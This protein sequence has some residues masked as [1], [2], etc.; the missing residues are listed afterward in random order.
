MA[1][2]GTQYYLSPNLPISNLSIFG[3]GDTLRSFAGMLSPMAKAP[4]EIA[5]DKQFFTRQPI[6]EYEG[7]TANYAGFELPAK[8][9][10]F[11][12]QLGSIPRNI[13]SIAEDITPT[14]KEESLVPP[15]PERSALIDITRVL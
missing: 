7:A 6:E 8:T 13:A 1:P 2:N 3:G 10:Y 15:N 14:V 4:I 11:L 5:M 9:A 12:N